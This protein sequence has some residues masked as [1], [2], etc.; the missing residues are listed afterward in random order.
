MYKFCSHYCLQIYDSR[1]GDARVYIFISWKKG[2]KGK[3]FNGKIKERED[4]V[5]V[6]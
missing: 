4:I 6:S 2:R 5:K 1:A 3:F